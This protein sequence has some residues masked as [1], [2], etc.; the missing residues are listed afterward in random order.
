MIFMENGK[1]ESIE[2][3]VVTMVAGFHRERSSISRSFSETDAS[4]MVLQ[5][6]NKCPPNIGLGKSWNECKAHFGEF[7][8]W[9]AKDKG[10]R[11][12]ED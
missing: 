9:I 10:N 11:R 5:Y 6:L 7:L 12:E 1:G 4:Q 3:T 2:N 8:A